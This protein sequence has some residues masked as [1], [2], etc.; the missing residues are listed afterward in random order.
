MY[1]MLLLFILFII[2][3]YYYSSAYLFS[4]QWSTIN[5]ILTNKQNYSPEQIRQVNKII[6][7]NYEKWASQKAI[8]FKQFHKYKCRGILNDE[9]KLYATIG[10]NKAIKN[11]DPSKYRTTNFDLYATNYVMGELYTGLTDLQPLPIVKKYERRKSFKNR[12]TNQ[13][14]QSIQILGEDENF[15]ILKSTDS[16][17]NKYKEY[18]E[19]WNKINDM[20]IPNFTKK[21][22][23]L[24]FSYE[25]NKIRSNQ[26][27]AT[28]MGCSEEWVRHHLLVFKNNFAK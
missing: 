26:Q 20:S 19:L 18:D 1:I 10:L 7:T 9:L 27:V 6:Y 22:L 13:T 8:Q 28:L 11:Y 24:K 15:D 21:I 5:N 16:Y 12:K 14:L 17:N 25:F 4:S 2:M 23:K 3:N